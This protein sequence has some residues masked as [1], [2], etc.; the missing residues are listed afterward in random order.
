MTEASEWL[1]VHNGVL[2]SQWIVVVV[3]YKG[4]TN[5]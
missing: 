5:S 3:A 2:G 1:G 4:V